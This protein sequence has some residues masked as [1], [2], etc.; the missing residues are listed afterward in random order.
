MNAVLQCIWN[1]NPL[2]QSVLEFIKLQFD[3]K[4]MTGEQALLVQIQ[5]LFNE[6]AQ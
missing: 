6:A 2:K 3:E 1:I 4:K 5:L